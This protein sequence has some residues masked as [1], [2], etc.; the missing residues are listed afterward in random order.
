MPECPGVKKRSG[1]A[2]RRRLN[3]RAVKRRSGGAYRRRLNVRAVK[4]AQRRRIPP[5]TGRYP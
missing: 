2:Y 5:P 1:G 4:K 3:V